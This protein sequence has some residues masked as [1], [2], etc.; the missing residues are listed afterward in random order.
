MSFSTGFSVYR[1]MSFANSDRFTFFFL[2]DCCGL[3]SNAM[4]NKSGKSGHPCLILDLTGNALSFSLLSKML[5]M[6]LSYMALM[7]KYVPSVSILLRV[8][9]MSGC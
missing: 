5:S 6:G 9:I 1:I 3:D 7:W 4:L 2:T 8:F